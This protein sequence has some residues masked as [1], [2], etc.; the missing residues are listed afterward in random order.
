MNQEPLLPELDAEGFLR[1]LNDWSPAVAAQLATAEGISMTDQHMEV[2]LL[3][4]SF[5][6]EYQVS[7]AM[8]IFVKQ[9]SLKLGKDK[10]N[11]LYLLGLFPGSPA[12]LA[13]KIAGLPKPTNCL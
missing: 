9:V 5:Y 6:Q 2:I 12:K 11:S 8:R 1:D 13:A 3:L 7:P 4:R 10:G